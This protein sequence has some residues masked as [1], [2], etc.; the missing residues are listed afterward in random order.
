MALRFSCVKKKKRIPVH[1]RVIC[2]SQIS[3]KSAF[4]RV[5]NK[6]Q[7]EIFALLGCYVT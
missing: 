2:T 7:H 1:T 6:M 4:P 3:F 5:I